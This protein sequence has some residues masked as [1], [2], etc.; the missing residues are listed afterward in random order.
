VPALIGGAAPAVSMP[1]GL[2]DPAS[3]FAPAGFN[4]TGASPWRRVAAPRR[5]TTIKPWEPQVVRFDWRPPASLAVAA[6][7]DYCALVALCTAADDPLPAA[8]AAGTTLAAFIAGERRAALRVVPVRPK[9]GA[10]LFIRDGVDDDARLG[11]VAF[12]GR[13]P[14]LIVVQ[15]EPAD[16]AQAF[17]DLLSSR[18]QDRVQ[19]GVA[20][21]VYVRVHNPGLEAADAEVHVWG[22]ALDALRTPAVPIASW[23]QLTPAAAPFLTVNVAAGSTALAHIVWNNP[24]DPSPGVAPKTLAIVATLRSTDN[25]DPLPN[26][27]AIDTV[28]K[29]F[30]FFGTLMDSDNAALRVL[31]A[32]A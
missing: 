25:T 28:D 14:D 4:P 8:L 13:S 26:P 3:L 7:N 31:G 10:S 20:N 2:P 6:P 11:G 1:A 5:I 9:A 12:T 15:A 29:F 17:R 16:P 18:P 32:S 24:P 19:L 30:A 23:T 22:V 27:A 21:H